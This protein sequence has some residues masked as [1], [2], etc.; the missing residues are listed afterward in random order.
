MLTQILTRVSTFFHRNTTNNAENNYFDQRLEC[1]APKRWSKCT[2]TGF[3]PPF[4]LRCVIDMIDQEMYVQQNIIFLL[5][6]IGS[7][8][9]H[10]ISFERTKKKIFS[11]KIQI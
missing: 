8:R 5:E 4:S 9:V 2:T 7:P 3:F 6:L 10:L 11:Y 1:A